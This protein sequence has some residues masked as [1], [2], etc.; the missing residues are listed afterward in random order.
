MRLDRLLG[1]VTVLLRNDRVTAPSLAERFEVSRRTI[2]RD[3]DALCQAGI[4]IITY[5]GGNGGISVAEGF[6]LEKGMLTTDEL[7]SIIAGL[8]GIGSV[9][10]Q[11]QVE[12]TL[13]IL[14]ANQNT[15]I[16]LR[17]PMMINLA[18]YHQGSLS[19][20]ITLI[21]KAIHEQCLVSFDYFYEKGE[22]GRTIEPYCIVFQWA[23]W[24]VFGYCLKR[25]DFRLFKLMRLW[26]VSLCA[27]SFVPREIPLEK[28]D[29]GM[30]FADDLTLVALF[31]PVAKYRLIETYGPNCYTEEEGMLRLEVKYSNRTYILGWLLSFGDQV[32][33]LEPLE[34]IEAIE[35]TAQKIIKRYS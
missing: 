13:A 17:E 7:M 30:Q 19:D 34:M 18:S 12:R 31:D 20:K 33:V 15:V 4:P 16:S 5:Q 10:D 23:A 24:Y 32:Q 27:E 29:F 2:G 35:Q 3:I 25:Q 14:S 21:K 28:G 26:N 6:R 9:L 8:K 1:I 11:T 22:T